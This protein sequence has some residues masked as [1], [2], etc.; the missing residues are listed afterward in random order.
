LAQRDVDEVVDELARGG[1]R[2]IVD[3]LT[4]RDA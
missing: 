3:P 4:H 1:A 2:G